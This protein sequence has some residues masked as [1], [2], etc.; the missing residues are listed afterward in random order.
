[1]VEGNVEEEGF[2]VLSLG[3]G[4]ALFRGEIDCPA[5]VEEPV[6]LGFA[7]QVIDFV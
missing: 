6:P 1:M 4:F 7:A 5:V 2:L 3:L